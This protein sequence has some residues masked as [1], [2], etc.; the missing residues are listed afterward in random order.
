MKKRSKDKLSPGELKDLNSLLL[1]MREVNSGHKKRMSDEDIKILSPE[2]ND[3]LW[4]YLMRISMLV[5]MYP[6]HVQFMRFIILCDNR[7]DLDDLVKEAQL[8]CAYWAY[9]HSWRKYESTEDCGMV[10]STANFGFLS[11]QNHYKNKLKLDVRAELVKEEMLEIH[12]KNN[13]FT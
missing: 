4:D 2:K 13:E 5:C 1:E 11:W 12:D 10:Y 9:R 7:I 8:D 3:R 6:N